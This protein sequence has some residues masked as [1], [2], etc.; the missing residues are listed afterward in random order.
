MTAEN[1]WEISR[2]REQCR[3]DV[4]NILNNMVEDIKAIPCRTWDEHKQGYI[5]RARVMVLAQK[6][7]LFGPLA[8]VIGREGDTIMQR[9]VGK[10]DFISLQNA[11]LQEKGIS[12]NDIH[13]RSVEVYEADEHWQNKRWQREY[14]RPRIM[15]PLTLICQSSR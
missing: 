5:A 3:E 8:A 9:A 13:K 1:A 10:V 2:T 6:A 11:I 4:V 14:A 7:T 12:N 15:R